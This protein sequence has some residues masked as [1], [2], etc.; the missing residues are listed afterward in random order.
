MDKGSTVI[1]AGPVEFAM[2]YR[3]EI[4]DDQGLCLQVYAKIDDKDTEILRFDCFDQNP[5]YHYG[6]ENHNIRLHMDKTTAGS[7]LGWTLGNI[8]HKLS[9]MVRRSG[10]EDL[11]NSVEANPMSATKM[12]ELETTARTMAAEGRRTVHHMMPELIEGDK[13][14]V[15]NLRFGLEYRHLP[16]ISDEGMAIH[17][18]ADVADQEVEL[19]AFDCFEKAP[20][21]HYGPRN[22]DV[23]VY[24]D[25]TT[26]GETLR[27][28]LDQFK[29]G[30]LRSMIERAGYPSIAASVDEKLVQ[31]MLPGIEARCFDL[32]S[33]NKTGQNGAKDDRKTKAQLIQ[34]LE[35]LRE[36]VAA[37]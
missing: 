7:S 15:G 6:P 14:E 2:S 30:N 27:W 31:E 4:M 21:Y 13:I 28:T 17:V 20:H 34:E 22:Q 25:V 37:L 3:Q 23:R 19:L 9:A 32:V 36:Q 24:W 33:Q 18:L 1:G 5:H 10:Y 16:Q 12:D 26:S 8:R 29:S 11:A 35:S